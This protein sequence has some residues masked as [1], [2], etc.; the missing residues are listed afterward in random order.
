MKTVNLNIGEIISILDP[1][2]PN[3][4]DKLQSALEE[5]V[6][7]DIGEEQWLKVWN[8]DDWTVTL[9]LNYAEAAA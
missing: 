2:N 1:L 9:T 3:A 7:K 4:Y 8:S 5:K 6:S